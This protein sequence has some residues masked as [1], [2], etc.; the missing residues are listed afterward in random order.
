MNL[1]R[2]AFRPDWSR[3]FLNTALAQAFSNLPIEGGKCLNVGCGT[4]GRYR[5]LL[6][7]YEVDA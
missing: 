3:I 4:E 1:S 5:E 7:G 6:S 2:Q